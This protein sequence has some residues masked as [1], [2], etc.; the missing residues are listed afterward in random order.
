VIDFDSR[1]ENDQEKRYF[2]GAVITPFGA[3]NVGLDQ[4]RELASLLPNPKLVRFV[5]LE[6]EILTDFLQGRPL[7]ER[8]WQ[9]IGDGSFVGSDGLVISPVDQLTDLGDVADQA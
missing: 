3:L 5:G 9:Q 8:Q 7:V 2:S 4:A 1:I 6:E